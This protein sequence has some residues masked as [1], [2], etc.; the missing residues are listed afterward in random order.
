MYLWKAHIGSNISFLC[1]VGNEMCKPVQPCV[2]IYYWIEAI[3]T[4]NNIHQGGYV[5][6]PV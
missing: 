2:L 6:T 5:V 4:S 3:E 1:W